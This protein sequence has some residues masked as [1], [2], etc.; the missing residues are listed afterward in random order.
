MIRKTASS[1]L[2]LLDLGSSDLH[3]EDVDEGG[4]ER[5]AS[6]SPDEQSEVTESESV[7]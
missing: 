6:V 4:D 1:A 5:G 2:A 3:A 7:A